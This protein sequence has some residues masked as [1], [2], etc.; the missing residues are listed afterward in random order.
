MQ[1]SLPSL[2]GG[3]CGNNNHIEWKVEV[4]ILVNINSPSRQS[5]T[6]Q[7]NKKRCNVYLI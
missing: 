2:T 3:M 6:I 5:C 1:F 4:N 7:T